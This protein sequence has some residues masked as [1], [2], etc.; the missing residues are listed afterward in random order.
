MIKRAAIYIPPGGAMAVG[1][2]PVGAQLQITGTRRASSTRR[3]KRASSTRRVKRAS[4][5]PARLV[6]GS[7]AAKRYMASIRRKR[8][9]R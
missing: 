8:R 4:K 3:K 1:G 2:L 9:K 7:A 6:K 5:R